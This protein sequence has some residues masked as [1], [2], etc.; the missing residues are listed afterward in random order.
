MLLQI[1]L[2]SVQCTVHSVLE[3]ICYRK[4]KKL[5]SPHYQ[6]CVWGGNEGKLYPCILRH[7]DHRQVLGKQ[8][9]RTYCRLYKA[10]DKMK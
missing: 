6:V 2:Y 5:P 9:P 7:V 10:Q 3:D 8:E 1:Q 4:F